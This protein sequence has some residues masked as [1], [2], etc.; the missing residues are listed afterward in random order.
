MNDTDFEVEALEHRG[1]ATRQRETPRPRAV[2]FALL[3]EQEKYRRWE[4]PLS[5]E[6][7]P[8]L[9]EIF[10]GPTYATRE[11]RRRA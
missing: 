6:A 4:G 7:F 1:R 10:R 5:R 9:W 3:D 8:I 11:R 2:S